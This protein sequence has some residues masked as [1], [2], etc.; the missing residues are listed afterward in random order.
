ML[1]KT[2]GRRRRWVTE[3]KIVGW[4]HQLNEHEFEQAPGD[5]EG[6]ASLVCCSPQG[7]FF[8]LTPTFPSL[9]PSGHTGDKGRASRPKQFLPQ[10]LCTCSFSTWNDFQLPLPSFSTVLASSGHSGLN[11]DGASLRGPTVLFCRPLSW[12]PGFP[13]RVCKNSYSLQQCFLE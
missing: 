7:L 3:D 8:A 5:R 4:H 6:Q 9:T 13:E 11:S 12:P 1:G 2:K 10:D